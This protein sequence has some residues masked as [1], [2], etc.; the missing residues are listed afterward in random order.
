MPNLITVLSNITKC[1][2]NY[3]LIQ[4]KYPSKYVNV[5]IALIPLKVNLKEVITPNSSYTSRLIE[6]LNLKFKRL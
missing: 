6:E 5:V 2:L 3:L 1:L 4:D